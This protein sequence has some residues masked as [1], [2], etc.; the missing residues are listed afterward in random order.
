VP[1]FGFDGAIIRVLPVAVYKPG[2]EMCQPAVAFRIFGQFSP[3]ATGLLYAKTFS[4]STYRT[5]RFY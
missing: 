2:L 5:V 3:F 1:P 4:L